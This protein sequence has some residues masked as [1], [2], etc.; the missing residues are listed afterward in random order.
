[1]KIILSNYDIIVCATL[2]PAQLRLNSEM[3]GLKN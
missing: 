3:H 1:M 2:A